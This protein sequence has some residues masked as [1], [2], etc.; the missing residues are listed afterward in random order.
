MALAYD[1]AIGALTDTDIWMDVG[2]TAAGYVAPWGAN[3]L[4]GGTLPPEVWGL[5]GM[6]GGEMMLDDRH[7]V[8]G[9]GAYTVDKAAERFGLKGSLREVMG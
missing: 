4:T 5:A 6:A 9:S 7:F 1:D 3:S 2:M 8:V